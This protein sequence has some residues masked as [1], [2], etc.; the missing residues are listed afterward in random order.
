MQ[1]AGG[2]CLPAPGAWWLQC[3]TVGQALWASIA[4][5]SAIQEIQPIPAIPCHTFCFSGDLDDFLG[6]VSYCFQSLPCFLRSNLLNYPKLMCS[7]GGSPF[8]ACPAKQV[9]PRLAADWDTGLS[10]KVM[11]QH[12]VCIC[13]MDV[14]HT[15]I[16]I[17]QILIWAGCGPIKATAL[18][19]SFFFL[20][21]Y[22][23]V[24]PCSNAHDQWLFIDCRVEF[25]SVWGVLNCSWWLHLIYADPI[26]KV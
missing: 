8:V 5:G 22:T 10:Q 17:P 25:V 19:V 14:I 1:I 3:H 18:L 9:H 24:L 20:R 16:W 23:Q 6:S 2:T 4:G 7:P 15:P 21:E 12:G 11:E 13:V 26:V